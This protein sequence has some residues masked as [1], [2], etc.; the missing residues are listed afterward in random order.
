DAGRRHRAP[1]AGEA[2]GSGPRC[3]A[4]KTEGLRPTRGA[5]PAI[6]ATPRLRLLVEHAELDAAVQRA[7]R[8]RSVVRDGLRLAVAPRQQ[9]AGLDALRDE[10]LAHGLGA[11]LRQLEVIG[12][13]A[14]AVGMARDLRAQVG[15]AA[16]R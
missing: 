7:S 10:E 16:Q 8:F 9:P 6:R 2:L 14:R 5:A 3:P 1:S 13:G 11:L 15:L 4:M 12:V